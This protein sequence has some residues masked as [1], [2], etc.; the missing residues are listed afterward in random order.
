MSE[1]HTPSEGAPSADAVEEHVKQA[2][3][4]L[5]LGSGNEEPDPA[6]ADNPPAD[7][8]AGDAKREKEPSPGTAASA[9][10]D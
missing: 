4:E 1:P 10:V 3:E 9:G 6:T 8:K 7:L 5:N 2:G